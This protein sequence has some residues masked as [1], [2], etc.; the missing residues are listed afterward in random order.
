[1]YFSELAREMDQ[2]RGAHLSQRKLRRMTIARNYPESIHNWM[3]VVAADC[4]RRRKW[5]DL[6]FEIMSDCTNPA[7]NELWENWFSR[8]WSARKEETVSTEA[9]LHA[10]PLLPF[11][12][13]FG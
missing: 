8:W 9:V 13:A 2:M 5:V 10:Q 7:L 11:H 12:F 6:S 3:L 1:M 4:A